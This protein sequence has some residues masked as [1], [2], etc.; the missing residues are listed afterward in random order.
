MTEP[1]KNT[2][3]INPD[4]NPNAMPRFG[5]DGLVREEIDPAHGSAIL[6]GLRHAKQYEFAS[7]DEVESA[8]D[9]FGS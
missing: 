7:D 5:R 6:E 8:F 2:G 1:L 3:A 9:S 4:E